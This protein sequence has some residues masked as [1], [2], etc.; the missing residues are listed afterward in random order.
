MD[1]M[2]GLRWTGDGCAASRL[3]PPPERERR[4]P[5]NL[6]SRAPAGKPDYPA[7]EC[8]RALACFA[9]DALHGC[10]DEAARRTPLSGIAVV[11]RAGLRFSPRTRA[12]P[13]AGGHTAEARV[14]CARGFCSRARGCAFA[15]VLR[16]RAAARG[17]A[18]RASRV[19]VRNV[20]RAT[21]RHGAGRRGRR[22]TADA[23]ATGGARVQ[24]HDALRRYY[25]YYYC[26]YRRRRRRQ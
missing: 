13:A 23:A 18:P 21:E 6:H 19:A 2:D 24:C 20:A 9:C 8:A 14:P 16:R 11:V 5:G 17:R 3:S 10:R 15:G 1:G 25:Y 7:G 22:T 12:A 4:N 26:C